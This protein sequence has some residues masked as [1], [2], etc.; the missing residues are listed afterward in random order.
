MLALILKSPLGLAQKTVHKLGIRDFSDEKSR[1][2]FNILKGYLSGRKRQFNIQYFVARLDQDLKEETER[3]YLLDISYVINDPVLL[4]KE[5]TSV[6]KTLKKRGIK[7]ELRSISTRIKEAEENKD[8][9]TL[10]KLSEEFTQL[11][12]RLGEV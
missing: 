7:R 12:K 11:S 5:L 6:F 10:K 1:E 3:L 9:K 8:G 4:E 2:L